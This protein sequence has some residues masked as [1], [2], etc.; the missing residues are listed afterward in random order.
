MKDFETLLSQI[1]WPRGGP[2]EIMAMCFSG[3]LPRTA[4][5]NTMILILAQQVLKR[6]CRL[7]LRREGLGLK[8]DRMLEA[9]VSGP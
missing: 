6:A 9:T 3:T 5:G 4:R 2:G 7:L 1:I 8:R